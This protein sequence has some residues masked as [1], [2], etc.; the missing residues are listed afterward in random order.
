MLIVKNKT[1]SYKCPLV[2][3]YAFYQEGIYLPFV[4][5][6]ICGAIRSRKYSRTPWRD[7]PNCWLCKSLSLS[8]F[9]KKKTSAFLNPISVQRPMK[10]C[11]IPV[12]SLS[13]SLGTWV[14]NNYARCTSLD[15]WGLGACRDCKNTHPSLSPTAHAICLILS[16]TTN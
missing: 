11:F 4:I 7:S 5:L 10:C 3:I 15:L 2:F 6:D 9:I 16:W 12:Q 8:L 13:L 14:D 1:I